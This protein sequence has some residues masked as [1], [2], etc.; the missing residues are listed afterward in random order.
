[1]PRDRDALEDILDSV[2]L[3]QQ[4]VALSDLHQFPQQLSMQD[5]VIRRFEL[6]GEATKRLS[7]ELR[8]DHPEIAWYAMASMR[9][10]V[11][12][13][14]DTVDVDIVWKTVQEDLPMLRD[15]IRAIL[16]EQKPET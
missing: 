2:R 1:M 13:G 12:H 5:A 9:D 7:Q 10:R 11:I 15:Q 8:N 6:I 4:Y 3:I 14:Y 16:E